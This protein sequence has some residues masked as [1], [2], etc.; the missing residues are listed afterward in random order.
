MLSFSMSN[1][2]YLKMCSDSVN[3]LVIATHTDNE[4]TDTSRNVNIPHADR[5][6]CVSRA[7]EIHTGAMARALQP[8]DGPKFCPI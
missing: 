5:S 7:T 2:L 6:G 3:I 4:N 8:A 1:G